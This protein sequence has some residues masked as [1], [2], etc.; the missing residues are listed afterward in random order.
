MINFKQKED[1]LP[2]ILILIS[3]LVMAACLIYSLFVPKPTTSGIVKGKALSIQK[4]NHEIAGAQASSK[5]VAQNVRQGVWTGKPET[6][7]ASVL[8]KLTELTTSRSLK[9]AAFR[10]ERSFVLGDLMECQYSVQITGDYSKV[11]EVMKALDDPKE[12]VVLRSVQINAAGGSATGIT[13]TLGISAY[14]SSDTF[15]RT[16]KVYHA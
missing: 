15:D 13:A 14:L 5:I 16:M 7:T 8:D 2:S 1:M 3:V 11:Y 4:I 6:V 12:K 9:M 10:P